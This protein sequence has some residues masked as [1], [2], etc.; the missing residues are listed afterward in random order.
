MARK[1]TPLLIPASRPR[2]PL[3]VEALTRRAGAHG[4]TGKAKRQQ[5]RQRV[6]NALPA[7]L[8]G[9]LAEFELD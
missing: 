1:T 3:A 5:M 2:N 4:N 7:L 8:A 9:D 6:H